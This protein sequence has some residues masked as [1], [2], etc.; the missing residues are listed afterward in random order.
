MVFCPFVLLMASSFH[1]LKII[2]SK[3]SSYGVVSNAAQFYT[4]NLR[5]RT[6]TF[7]LL[8]LLFDGC[9]VGKCHDTVLLASNTKGYF[10][11]CAFFFYLLFE[12][13]STTFWS[14]YSFSLKWYVK[15]RNAKLEIAV[16]IKKA[17]SIKNWSYNLERYQDNTIYHCVILCIFKALH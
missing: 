9:V 6:R 12:K 8:L 1:A 13:D 5:A 15:D 10:C 4:Q 2:H 3:S 11:S 16:L 14:Q 17:I 7:L